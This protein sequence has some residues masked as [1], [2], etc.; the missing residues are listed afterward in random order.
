MQFS[1][2]TIEKAKKQLRKYRICDAMFAVFVLLLYF[3]IVFNADAL[4]IWLSLVVFVFL[5]Y[6][7]RVFLTR[8]FIL[9][10][11]VRDLDA[12]TFLAVIHQGRFDSPAA[13][14]QLMG[15]Y[16]YGNYENVISICNEKLSDA[17]AAKKYVFHYL[18]YLG[19]V[20]FEIGDD[21]KL[22]S[23]CECFKTALAAESTR[24]QKRYKKRF[25]RMEF[26]EFYLNRDIEAC[27]K[28]LDA[29]PAIPIN[30]RHRTFCKARLAVLQGNIE[31]AKLHYQDLAQNDPQL[32]YGKIAQKS[33]EQLANGAAAP[34]TLCLATENAGNNPVTL[35][36]AKHYKAR[37]I[38]SSCLMAVVGILLLAGVIWD[39]K[40]AHDMNEH[41][42]ELR[43][44]VEVDYDGV[45][46]LDSFMLEHNGEIVDTVFICRTNEEVIICC[47]YVY[48]GEDKLYYKVMTDIPLSS[49]SENRLFS[50][51]AYTSNYNIKSAIYT[52][53]S[54]VPDGYCHLSMF[55]VDGKTVYYV[56]TEIVP[57]TGVV[58][59]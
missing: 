2:E 12:T 47:A 46:V 19:N 16:S 50:F 20:Y 42:E 44:V 10:V 59:M 3:W 11:V 6:V 36:T 21:E 51:P 37:K 34:E 56:I 38:I 7:G 32:N 23:T 53:I 26:Y 8:K 4:I 28:W 57:N 9:S 14:W 43:S 31:E 13:L 27:E 17:Q 39:I 52:D 15:E 49:L 5:L 40:Y 29:V 41:Y 33:L 45:E 18:W 25:P 48:E 55:E 30:Q 58:N 1:P 22:R 35:Y 54:E 24:K